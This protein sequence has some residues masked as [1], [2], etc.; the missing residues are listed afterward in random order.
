MLNQV[1]DGVWV[2]Q[3]EWVWSNAIVV[4]GE[5][6]ARSPT[7]LTDRVLT[8]PPCG[9]ARPARCPPAHV[10]IR[11]LRPALVVTSAPAAGSG[12]PAN[13]GC[14][15][16]G[17]AGHETR[18]DAALCADPGDPHRRP[19]R[20]RRTGQDPALLRRRPRLPTHDDLH[21]GRHAR[22]PRARPAGCP[23]QPPRRAQGPTPS[24]RESSRRDWVTAPPPR[25]NRQ[26][27]EWR[28]PR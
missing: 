22:R 17:G 7:I 14:I 9:V 23:P 24:R 8:I 10:D 2:R 11:D 16:A 28:N 4:R 12:S 13:L 6:S 3:S 27:P 21:D 26:P 20:T 5:G 25:S 15:P 18:A 1:A 19:R